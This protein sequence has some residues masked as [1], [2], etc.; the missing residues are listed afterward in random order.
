MLVAATDRSCPA[1]SGEHLLGGLGEGGGRGRWSPRGS[2]GPVVSGLPRR[3]RPRPA[4]RPYWNTATTAWPA[5]VWRRVV[6]GR[7]AGRGEGDRVVRALGAARGTGRTAPRCRSSRATSSDPL[8]PPRRNTAPRRRAA[9]AGRRAAGPHAGCS[10]ISRG[11][12]AH[13]DRY[14]VQVRRPGREVVVEHVR[15]ARA[16]GSQPPDVLASDQP[17]RVP[18]G[19]GKRLGG[20]DAE[21]D[22]VAIGGARVSALP[23]R[24]PALVAD[25][26]GADL[27]GT[28]ARAN[29]PSRAAGRGRRVGDQDHPAGRGRARPAGPRRRR[30]GAP[31]TTSWT[32]TSG[33]ARAAPGSPGSRCASGLIALNRWVTERAPASK[34]ACACVGGRVG[35]AEGDQ[36]ALGGQ[37]RRS[38]PGRRAARGRG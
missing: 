29:R 24:A 9:A 18:R 8:I 4:T 5:Q 35:V 25:H 28:P 33:R 22:G 7:E 27:E 1:S 10:A 17:Q 13:A 26:P 15:S 16:P 14:A 36:H 19:S 38:G 23:A 37:A 20:V 2:V 3:R 12:P 31:S 32:V 34:P 21:R 11:E 30:D 6:H